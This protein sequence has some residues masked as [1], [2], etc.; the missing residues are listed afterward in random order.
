MKRKVG[1]IAVLLSVS[2]LW[3]GRLCAQVLITQPD[4]R[5]ATYI[6]PA[7]FGPNAFQVPEMNDGLT[8]GSFHAELAADY[9]KGH[10]VEG[11]LDNTWDLFLKFRIPLFSERV[12]LTLWAPVQEWYQTGREVLM[13]R[14]ADSSTSGYG[15][16]TGAAFISVDILLLK[17]TDKRP[18]FVLRSVLRTALEDRAFEKAR[19][20][21]C[22]GY[23]FDLTAGKS[24]GPVRFAV[25]SGFLCWQTDN[26]RQN[27]AFMFGVL[28]EYFNTWFALRA[29]YGGYVGWEKCG[30][31]P[32]TLRLRLDGGPQ[33]WSVRPF[34][35]YQHGF[36]DW[37]FDQLR[38]GV[39]VTL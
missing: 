22:P 32:R 35:L 7:W 17:E 29:Q 39:T 36:S 19:S 1:I 6:A 33:A 16:V 3:G 26:G 23:F 9:I 38:A 10:L 18:S 4:F 30:D 11:A 25:S 15:H 8:A 12:N 21:D 27:D 24:F 28:G 31:F 2:A 37:P 34:F 20:F 13:A 5:K 14:R